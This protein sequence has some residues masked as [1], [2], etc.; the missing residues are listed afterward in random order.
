MQFWFL[1]G[2]G[3]IDA[4]Y[5]LRRQEEYRNMYKKLCMCFVDM[6]KAF[7]RVPRKVVESSMQ[8]RCLPKMLMKTTMSLY[9]KVITR[10]RVG[11]RLAEEFLC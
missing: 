11:S 6:E 4:L 1:P 7:H 9:E 2:R 8:Q 5:I 3:T 10:T